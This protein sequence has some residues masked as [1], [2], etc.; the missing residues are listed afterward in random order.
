[1]FNE[2]IYNVQRDIEQNSYWNKKMSNKKLSRTR[3]NDPNLQR[4]MAKYDWP[5]PSREYVLQMV[6][7][8]GKP[9]SFEEL[10]ALLDIHQD[11]YDLFQRRLAAMEREAVA[12]YLA[13]MPAAT[14]FT[15][16]NL[17]DDDL[18]ARSRLR[19]LRIWL[20]KISTTAS[21][22]IGGRKR[23]AARCKRNRAP[24]N[25]TSVPRCGATSSSAAIA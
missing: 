11:E 8:Q 22:P 6:E 1:M 7:E 24:F 14:A 4:E 12:H 19:S 17:S 16:R 23:C 10:C 25:A 3:K 20:S 21:L 5:L 18:R 2:K 15:F 13:M 9:V